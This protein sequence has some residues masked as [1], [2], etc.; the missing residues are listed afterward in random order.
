[1]KEVNKA[2][3]WSLNNMAKNNKKNTNTFSNVN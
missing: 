3:Y 2:S 1:M